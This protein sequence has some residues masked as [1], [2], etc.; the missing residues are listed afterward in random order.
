MV[1]IFKT[2]IERFWIKL[3]FRYCE[4]VIVNSVT[5]NKD[6]IPQ[7]LNG[8]RIAVRHACLSIDRAQV[9]KGLG[10]R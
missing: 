6:I 1:S 2:K 4:S 8:Q 7:K 3:N 9:K 5:V 10:H